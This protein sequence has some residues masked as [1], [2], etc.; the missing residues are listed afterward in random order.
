MKMSSGRG[1][2]SA[3]IGAA[4]L[5]ALVFTGCDNPVLDTVAQMRAET[6]TA[7]KDMTAFSIKDPAVI[8]TISGTD[9]AVTVPYGTD[10]T[11]LVAVFTITGASVTVNGVTQTSNVT[12]NNF[13]SPV[14]YLV[15]ASDGS[16]QLYTVTVTLGV[17]TPILSATTAASSVSTSTAVS[18][19]TITA[20]GGSAITSSGIC[21]N[22]TENPTVDSCA[23][24]TTDGLTSAGS[25]TSTMTGLTD[26]TTYYVRAYATNAIG[27]GYGAQVSF[28]TISKTLPVLSATATVTSIGTTTAY[29]GGTI[30]TDNDS[31]IMV[32]GVC[33]S[34]DENPT[35]TSCTGKTT[36]GATSGTWSD[37]YMESLS[38]GTKY[39]VRAYA[40][41]AK[42]TGYGPQVGFTTLSYVSTAPTLTVVGGTAGSGELT[43]SWS[44]ATGAT[45]YDVYY[46]TTNAFAGASSVGNVTDTSLTLTSLTNF[47]QLYYVWIVARNATGV[48]PQS[49][50]NSS[51]VGVPVT[52]ITLQRS[53]DT[54][55]ISGGRTA[56]AFVYYSRDTLVAT[57][58]PMDATVPT[59]SWS[60]SSSTYAAISA[61]SLTCLI[62]AGSAAGSAT[63]KATADDGQGASVS[64]AITV[65]SNAVGQTGPGGGK[66]VYDQ[67]S[68]TTGTSTSATYGWRYLETSVASTSRT[69]YF[70]SKSLSS[71][72]PT[73]SG[74]GYGP[75]NTSIV[76]SHFGT[77][78][79]A[80]YLAHCYQDSATG[81]AFSDWFLPSQGEMSISAWLTYAAI[82]SYYVA[83]SSYA[84]ASMSSAEAYANASYDYNG[85]SAVTGWYWFVN[86][87]NSHEI[88][89]PTRRF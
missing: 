63:V 61:S 12:I 41:N 67:G 88:Y 76:L 49:P 27:T 87:A 85:S 29:S 51:I 37:S 43:V 31:T 70:S 45:S 52:A 30:T 22:T 42:G 55:S 2:R 3:V 80:A 69:A 71:D 39:Y 77:A 36:D 9:V 23:G 6:A 46:N 28:T 47:T 15:A 34:T 75:T 59:V 35:I 86:T 84:N 56:D 7:Q 64:C 21:W 72:D 68:Y 25:W 57:I 66:I 20:N 24:K 53:A 73:Y 26:G 62:T 74:I 58:T 8:G 60:T 13:T 38:I 4:V 44:A 19:G 48:G 81:G 33:W 5:L 89:V 40:T 50:S 79:T 16:T 32:S 11:G 83:W 14:G 78:S 65:T 18:G 17:T 54:Q 82:P 10:L 1:A